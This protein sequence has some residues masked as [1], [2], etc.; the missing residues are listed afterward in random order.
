MAHNTLKHKTDLLKE[1]QA[2]DELKNNYAKNN[3]IPLVRIPYYKRDTIKI[4]E[5]LGDQFLI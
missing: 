2:R 4:E 3:S 1:V 5:L